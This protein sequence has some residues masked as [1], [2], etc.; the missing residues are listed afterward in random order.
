MDG[1]CTC[2][3]MRKP[4]RVPLVSAVL[5]RGRP[6]AVS[7]SCCSGRAPLASAVTG[8]GVWGLWPPSAATR[9]ASASGVGIRRSG[10][11]MYWAKSSASQD[12]VGPGRGLP[13]RRSGRAMYCGAVWSLKSLH[14]QRV[15]YG[16]RALCPARPGPSRDQWQHARALGPKNI[17]SIHAPKTER[18]RDVQVYQASPLDR[19]W[20]R[21]PVCC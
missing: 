12:G 6:S 15:Q 8:K 21:D 11:A 5:R 20:E 16:G 9:I 10:P 19:H 14:A 7:T 17:W 2:T 3:L 4:S 1:S 18:E 13:S